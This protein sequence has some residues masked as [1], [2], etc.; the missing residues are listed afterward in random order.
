MHQSRR[1]SLVEAVANVVVG[2]L[3]ALA[4]QIVVFPLFGVHISMA[5]DF[6][7]GG[8]FALI[9]LLRGFMLRRIFERLG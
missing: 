1:M 6:A 2:Y 9:S 8:I 7:I 3:L 4:T 5:D